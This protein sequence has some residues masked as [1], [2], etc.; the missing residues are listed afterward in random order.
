MDEIKTRFDEDLGALI[1]TLPDFVTLEA[2]K[3]WEAPFFQAV[4]HRP[5]EV[6]LLFDTNSH[7]FES[8]DCLK[9][10]KQFFVER[11]LIGSKVSPVAFVQPGQH[12]APQVASD[13]EAYF[14]TVQ[15]ARSWLWEAL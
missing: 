6:G 14:L 11:A 3:G 12:K 5:G 13:A 10:L 9:W 7:N 1:V 2:L 8:I 4:E 15:E